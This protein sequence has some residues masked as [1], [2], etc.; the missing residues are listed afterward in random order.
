MSMTERAP[1]SQDVEISVD[2]IMERMGR[3]LAQANVDASVQEAR[4]DKLQEQV[5]KLTEELAQTRLE[6][7]VLATPRTPPVPDIEV[8]STNGKMPAKP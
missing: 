6:R 2:E 7:D 5:N 8:E 1:S 4:A 3:R